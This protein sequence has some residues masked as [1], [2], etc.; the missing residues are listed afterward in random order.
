MLV[1]VGSVSG[2]EVE[3]PREFALHEDE[4]V[5]SKWEHYLH[6]FPPEVERW[7][8]EDARRLSAIHFE[9]GHDIRGE[10]VPGS[11]SVQPDKGWQG[12]PIWKVEWRLSFTAKAIL[13]R[14][15]WELAY[16]LD[17]MGESIMRSITGISPEAEYDHAL[18]LT[19]WDDWLG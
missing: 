8:H 16:F 18:V 1:F 11:G 15:L 19:V 3:V 7:V 5:I 4:F 17:A 12:Q 13:I 14:E 9:G 10:F 6:E 2:K